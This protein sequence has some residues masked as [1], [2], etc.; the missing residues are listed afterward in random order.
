M[1][2][3]YIIEISTPFWLETPSFG[4]L[5]E[6]RLVTCEDGAEEDLITVCLTKSRI[7]REI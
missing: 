4:C 1:K 3:G 5:T 7:E 6:G 2:E